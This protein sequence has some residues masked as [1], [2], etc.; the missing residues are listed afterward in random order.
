MLTENEKYIRRCIQLAQNGM[1]ETS[2]NPRVGAVIV[3]DKKIIG[4]GY[5][6]RHGEP[7]AEVNAINAVKNKSLLEESTLYVSLE[8]CSHFGKTPPCADLIIKEKIPKIV[9]GCLDPSKKVA[10][11]GVK[12][13]REANREVTTGVLEQECQELIKRFTVFNMLNR[14]YITLKWAQSADGYMDYI[15]TGGKATKL[16]SDLSTL[17]THKRRAETDAILVGTRTALLDNPSLNVRHW[18]GENPL[19]LVLDR[20]LTLPLNLN[21]FKDQ[22]PTV[23]LSASAREGKNNLQYIPIKY[24]KDFLANLL[25]ELY[26]RNIQSVLVEGGSQ[27]LQTFINENLW[28]EAFIEQTPILLNKGIEAPIIRNA[29]AFKEEIFF[30]RNFYCY[31]NCNFPK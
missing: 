17:I 9:I 20:N 25:S 24:G 4:E 21:I 27:L 11:K 12:K 31:F 22:A 23:I 15:R 7:H 19:R 1:N 29:W 2:P 3:H 16:S 13:L 5:H 26:A 18:Y 10:G 8:P 30:N 14:P 6:I 28:D